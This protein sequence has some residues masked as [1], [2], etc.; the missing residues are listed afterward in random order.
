MKFEDAV[1]EALL[2][3]LSKVANPTPNIAYGLGA[4]A[5]SRIERKVNHTFY[6]YAVLSANLYNIGFIVEAKGIDGSMGDA[7]CQYYR[8]GFLIINARMRFNDEATTKKL[9]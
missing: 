4:E 9:S 8:G 7:Q 5:F 2:Q 1:T 6:N 3:D